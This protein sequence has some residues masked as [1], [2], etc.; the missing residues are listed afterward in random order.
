[1][2]N[3]SVPTSHEEA[4]TRIERGR[5]L[6]AEHSSEIRYSQRLRAWLVPSQND[7]TSVYEVILRRDEE[8]CEC[9][10]LEYSGLSFCKHIVAA[11]LRKSKTSRCEG[12]G[13]RF[14]NC[15]LFEAPDDHLTFF[16][17][18]ALCRECA[19]RSGVL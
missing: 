6:Y 7:A 3:T 19:R 5:R 12:C 16:E 15:E 8:T 14:P 9:A 17:G 10:D 11:T 1:M 2:A 13:D 18:D 4:T